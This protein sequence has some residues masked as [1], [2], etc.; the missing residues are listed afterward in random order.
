MDD[1]T[2][3]K[4]IRENTKLKKV[5]SLTPEDPQIGVTRYILEIKPDVIILQHWDNTSKYYLYL[6]HDAQIKQTPTGFAL[7]KN[8]TKLVEYQIQKRDYKQRIIGEEK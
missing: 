5:F 6:T 3:L 2:K 8:Q 4:N 7:F 1:F